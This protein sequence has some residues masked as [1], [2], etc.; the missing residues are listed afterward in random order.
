MFSCL[1]NLSYMSAYYSRS[2]QTIIA[3]LQWKK[4][5]ESVSL[6]PKVNFKK[7][8]LSKLKFELLKWLRQI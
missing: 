8:S 6:S 5:L 7:M 1:D 4:Y 2:S 3:S